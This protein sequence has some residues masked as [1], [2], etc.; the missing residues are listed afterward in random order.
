REKENTNEE[1]N[2]L[3]EALANPEPNEAIE[4]SVHAA[5]ALTQDTT[6]H[7][8]LA[9]S[10]QRPKSADC[11]SWVANSNDP[12]NTLSRRSRAE[13][14]P[15]F[16]QPA[17]APVAHVLNRHQGGRRHDQREHGCKTKSEYDRGREV[18]P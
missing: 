17:Q 16:R 11:L 9:V 18:D 6:N 12:T 8:S 14:C 10:D 15:P 4:S 1:Q 5:I 7:P 3:D 13:L 2:D